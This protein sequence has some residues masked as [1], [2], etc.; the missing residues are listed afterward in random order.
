MEEPGEPLSAEHQHQG[1][2]SLGHHL[3]DLQGGANECSPQSRM[4][5]LQRG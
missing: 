1:E 2:H 3:W 4:N 5:R